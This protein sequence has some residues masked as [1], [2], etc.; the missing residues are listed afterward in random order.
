MKDKL[1]GEETIIMKH[2]WNLKEKDKKQRQ[3]LMKKA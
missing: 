2:E 1:E 3:M